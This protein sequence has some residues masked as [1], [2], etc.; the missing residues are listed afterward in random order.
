MHRIKLTAG[1]E[2]WTYGIRNSAQL[3][4]YL[5]PQYSNKKKIF[6]GTN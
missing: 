1:F 4:S 3:G 5:R 6:K 2:P